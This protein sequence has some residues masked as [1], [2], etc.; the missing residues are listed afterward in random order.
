MSTI[1]L[2]WFVTHY[3]HAKNW[4]RFGL[5]KRTVSFHSRFIKLRFSLIIRI[6]KITPVK[7]S[8]KEGNCSEDLM[9]ALLDTLAYVRE[10]IAQN[11]ESSEQQSPV[12]FYIIMGFGIYLWLK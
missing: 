6:L 3:F 7:A 5:G 2:A 4:K 1:I 10:R 8:I 11:A 12:H 9:E